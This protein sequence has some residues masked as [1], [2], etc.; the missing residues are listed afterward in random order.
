MKAIDRLVLS[1]VRRSRRRRR[2]RDLRALPGYVP[3]RSG[4]TALSGLRRRSVVL[5]VA[6]VCAV[7]V[8]PGVGYGIALEMDQRVSEARYEAAD[9]EFAQA[10]A[11]YSA[12]I[13]VEQERSGVEP[14][15]ALEYVRSYGEPESETAREL[16]AELEAAASAWSEAAKET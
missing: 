2:E 14:D 10:S 9:R 12:A 8:L 15:N 6:S 16:Q 13:A 4:G 1:A 3:E 7:A 11:A 5:V